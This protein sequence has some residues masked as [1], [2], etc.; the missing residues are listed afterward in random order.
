MVPYGTGFKTCETCRASA[1]LRG[2]KKRK[3]DK[4]EENA[5]AAKRTWSEVQ[6]LGPSSELR[7]ISNAYYLG[8]VH[9]QHDVLPCSA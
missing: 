2:Q 8:K 1:K 6:P 4:E 7:Q 5:R 3:K 9:I